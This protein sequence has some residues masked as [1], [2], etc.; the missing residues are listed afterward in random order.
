MCLKINSDGNF[1]IIGT[2]D[3]ISSGLVNIAYLFPQKSINHKI[4]VEKTNIIAEKL[5]KL[6]HI[7]DT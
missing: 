2:F 3:K 5:V 6:G 1:K 4:I 7:G